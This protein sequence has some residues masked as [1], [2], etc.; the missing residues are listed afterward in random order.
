[1]TR[2]G[3]PYCPEHV[4]DHPYVRDLL[5]AL[6]ARQAEEE[7]VRTRG[8][9]EVDLDGITA[10]EVVLHLSL[11]GARTIERISRE[12]QIDSDVVAGYVDA[13]NE[14]DLIDMSHTNRGSTVVKLR[15][16][17]RALLQI[18]SFESVA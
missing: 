18:C 12:L 13:L 15:D 14:R 11:H 3:K 4:D 6:A 9:V 10:R 1:M 2:E 5:A 16:P 7:R 17:E 8:S